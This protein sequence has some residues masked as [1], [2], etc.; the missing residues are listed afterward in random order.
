M[1]VIY[2]IICLSI[3]VCILHPFIEEL[4]SL[5]PPYVNTVLDIGKSWHPY[6]LWESKTIQCKSQTASF[7]QI[8]DCYNWLVNQVVYIVE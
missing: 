4:Y 3:F 8:V 6:F 7:S 5:H 2:I 1:E